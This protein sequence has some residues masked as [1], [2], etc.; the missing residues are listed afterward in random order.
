M[1]FVPPPYARGFSLLQRGQYDEG[2]VALRA[3][4]AAD[5]LVADAA[6]RSEPMTQGSAALRQ[7]QVARANRALRSCGGGCRRIVRGAP[8]PGHGIRIRG[9][10]TRSVRHLRDA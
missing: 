8:A 5:P 7:G 10:I 4:V 6:S 1:G 2:L 3:A 9:D